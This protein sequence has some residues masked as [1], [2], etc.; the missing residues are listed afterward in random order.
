MK[1]MFFMKMKFF[2]SDVQSMFFMKKGE[3]EKIYRLRKGIIWP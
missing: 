1:S 3:E 2:N